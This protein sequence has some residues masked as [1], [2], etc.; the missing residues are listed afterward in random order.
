MKENIQMRVRIKAVVAVLSIAS[1]MVA[2]PTAARGQSGVT[3]SSETA[4]RQY[5]DF[6][7]EGSSESSLNG[8]LASSEKMPYI[9]FPI[10][11]KESLAAMAYIELKKVR[12]IKVGPPTS[13]SSRRSIEVVLAGQEKPVKAFLHQGLLVSDSGLITPLWKLPQGGVLKKR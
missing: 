11:D 13:D 9:H 7:P 6:Y 5:F 1:I 12:N 8:Y 4:P 3:I 10:Y 2:Y